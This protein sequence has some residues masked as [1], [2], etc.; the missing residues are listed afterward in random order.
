MII[1]EATWFAVIQWQS[2]KGWPITG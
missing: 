2:T 1:L